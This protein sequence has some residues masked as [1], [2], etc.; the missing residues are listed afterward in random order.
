M[1]R[2]EF[3]NHYRISSLQAKYE[4]IHKPKRF[5][6]RVL[7]FAAKFP[8]LNNLNRF[9]N[10]YS[11]LLRYSKTVPCK[12]ITSGTSLLNIDFKT[13]EFIALNISF[14]TKDM[15]TT[16]MNS[17]SRSRYLFYESTNNK[18]IFI[19]AY[20]HDEFLSIVKL[21]KF[22]SDY[23][24]CITTSSNE[25]SNLVQSL[26]LDNCAVIFV[27]N[28]G[29]DVAP[30]Y[31]SLQ[32]IDISRY[33]GFIKVHTKRS[34]HLRTGSD[35]FY[36]N[37]NLLLGNKY[38]SDAAISRLEN[39]ESSLFGYSKLKLSDHYSNN[40]YWL[41]YL[42]PPS[43]DLNNHYFIPGTMFIGNSKFL[44]ALSS[45]DF[46]S[47]QLEP[48]NGQL[49]GCFIHSIERYLGYLCSSLGGCCYD[50]IDLSS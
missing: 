38:F 19:H 30:L 27:P 21:I 17:S 42:L 18:I 29:R 16:V 22:F 15:N 50:R 8:V 23:D 47:Y 3:I 34:S 41:E 31:Y 26:Q 5:L 46:L 4:L 49:D 10:I 9:Y 45:F 37:I 12:P 32:C 28:N 36:Q 20:Y 44:E 14:P 2:S 48:E 11:G 13:S 7:D 39:I 35:W 24:I 43:I 33:I 25:I 6:F 40:K 1:N